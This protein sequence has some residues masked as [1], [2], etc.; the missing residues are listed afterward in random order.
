M[1]CLPG[2]SFHSILLRNSGNLGLFGVYC[3]FIVLK[4]S[5]HGISSIAL[6]QRFYQILILG[7]ILSIIKMEQK[8]SL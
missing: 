5:G 7:I 8:I 1:V 2:N 4:P 6:N 3:Y